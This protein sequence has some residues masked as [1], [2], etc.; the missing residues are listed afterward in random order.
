L[1][2]LVAGEWLESAHVAEEIAEE[3]AE[4]IAVSSTGWYV[5][6]RIG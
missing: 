4:E 5:E 2:L 1:R 6:A 3:V